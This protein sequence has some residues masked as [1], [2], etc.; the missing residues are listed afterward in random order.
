MNSNRKINGGIYLV[1]DPS[2]GLE[3]ILSKIKKAIAGGIEVLQV[4]NNWNNEQNK[5]VVIEAICAIAHANNVP[6]MINE[7][8]QLLRTTSLDGV[9]L[10]DIPED[11]DAIKQSVSKPFV[12][13]ITCG[14]DLTR[15]EWANKN[16]LHYISFCSMF[17]SPSAGV[18]EIV[19]KE[20]VIKARQLTAL[21]IFVA[22]GI[23][24]NNVDEL[25]A[26]GI[27]G[28]A[29]I[30]GIMKADDPQATTEQFKQKLADLKTLNNE[31][32]ID[33]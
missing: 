9:H 6:V 24:L 7:D 17:P 1:V 20:T 3:F 26:A 33:E 11:I 15:I 22:G 4:W 18:C 14:N 28:I 2:L 12:I 30:S 16:H 19:D 8:W 31:T 29:L 23:T 32:V 13:G 21:P 27:D 10:D 25:P 5:T